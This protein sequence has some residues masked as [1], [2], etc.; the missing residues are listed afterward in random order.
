MASELVR[1][2]RVL[3]VREVEREVTQTELAVKMQ[4]EETILDKIS[5]IEARRNDALADFCSGRDAIVSPQQL[6]FERQNLDVMEKHLSVNR[7]EL[8]VCRN[9]IEE[10][11]SVLLE[12]HRNVQM[13]ERYVGKLKE[14]NDKRII[15]AEQHNLDDITSMRYLRNMRREAQA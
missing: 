4:E 10:T 3:R 9:E 15:D 2:K 12:R 13:M 14:R 6:W 5:S 7:D 8:A 11:K 1:F